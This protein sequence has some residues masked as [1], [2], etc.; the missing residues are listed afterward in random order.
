MVINNTVAASA[1][2]RAQGYGISRRSLLARLARLSAVAGLM[3]VAGFVAVGTS[4][5]PPGAQAVIGT[6]SFVTGGLMLV[7]GVPLL[8]VG[9]L[10]R[11]IFG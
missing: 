11:S 6:A 3:M 2:A 8:L 1:S 10:W 9:G 7:I 5:H 4:P